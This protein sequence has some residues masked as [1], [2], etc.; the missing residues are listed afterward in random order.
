MSRALVALLILLLPSAALAEDK[1]Q[2]PSVLDMLS[3]YRDLNS[4]CRNPSADDFEKSAACTTREK[5]ARML[6]G[7]GWCYGVKGDD[8]GQRQWHRCGQKELF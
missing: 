5:V 3:V 8:P 1:V 2:Q 4:M 6:N 7:M